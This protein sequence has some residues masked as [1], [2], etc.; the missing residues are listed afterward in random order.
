VPAI[1][2]DTGAFYALADRADRNHSAAKTVFEARGLSG[3]LVTSDY[4]FV[5]SRCL[6]RARLGR[7]AAMQY[8]DAM[9]SDVVTTYGVTS[10]DLANA[11]AIAAA[12]P[13]QD[14]SLIDCTSFALMERLRLDEALAFDAHFRIYRFGPQRQR[15]FRIVH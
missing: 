2:V 1:F 9:Q 11:R 3:E 10:R 12:W 15:A 14:F 8:W 7:G 4:V 13:D 6:I 5:E